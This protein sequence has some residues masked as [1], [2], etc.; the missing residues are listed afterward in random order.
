MRGFLH[1]TG[2]ATPLVRAHG[3]GSPSGGGGSLRQIASVVPSSCSSLPPRL[4]FCHQ[5]EGC[6]GEGGEVVRVGV[7]EGGK[8]LR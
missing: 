1:L 4:S 5:L 6:G 3:S 2:I 8:R 7:A